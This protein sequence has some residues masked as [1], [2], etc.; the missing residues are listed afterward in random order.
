ML[1]NLLVQFILRLTFG[2]AAAMAV[3][4]PE[5]VTAGYFR[6]HLWVTLG[7]STFA[8]VAIA[9]GEAGLSAHGTV[10][11]LAVATAISSYLGS[12]I[13]LYERRRAG[14]AALLTVA[15]L[16]F[17]AAIQSASNHQPLQ[18]AD[19]A[20]SGLFLGCV[21]AAMFLG[22]WYLNNPG[23][24]LAPLQRLILGIVAVGLLRSLVCGWGAWMVLNAGVEH[25]GLWWTLLAMRWIAGLLATMFL[26]ALTWQTLKIPNTQSATGILYVA[27]ITVFLGELSSLFLSTTTPFPL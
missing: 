17:I 7:L 16:G 15:G 11:Q 18:L 5:L 13:W 6:V 26:A 24:Q 19:I 23:M 10:F 3:T 1:W 25:Q 9:S 4:S 12:V 22:H 8:A 2:L 27:V 14:R 21:I 20:T